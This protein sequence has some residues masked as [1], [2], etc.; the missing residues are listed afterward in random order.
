[1]LKKKCSASFFFSYIEY[2]DNKTQSISCVSLSVCV[3]ARARAIKLLKNY[4]RINK[5]AKC[6]AET[7]IAE[8]VRWDR[9]KAQDIFEK[10]QG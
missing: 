9:D 5:A 3:C 1:V 6:E 10:S 2:N 4:L 7:A 8:W